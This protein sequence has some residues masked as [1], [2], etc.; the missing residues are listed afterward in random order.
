[1][2]R[3]E[4]NY[5]TSGVLTLPQ[6]WVLEEVKERRVVS[7]HE[8]AR[9][10]RLKS[11]SATVLVDRLERLGLIRRQRGSEDRRVV[12]VGL[13]PRGKRVLQQID[14]H[15]KEGTRRLFRPL[16]ARERGHYLQL[17]EKMAN[18]LSESEPPV[19]RKEM[20]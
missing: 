3:H 1:M 13:T 14:A 12:R 4:S 17:I 11:S 2:V 9:A 19:R 18:A 5:L 7:M 8:L 6:L 20:S 15:R 16:T 10:V